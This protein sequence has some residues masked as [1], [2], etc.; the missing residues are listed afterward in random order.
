V[1]SGP[2]PPFR[3]V[4]WDDALEQAPL[5]AEVLVRGHL[6]VERWL[7]QRAT[8][9]RL[10]LSMIQ[11]FHRVMFGDVFPD[12][13]GRLRG[14]APGCIPTN[15]SL[16]HFYGTRY[17]DVLA[18]CN[19]MCSYLDGAI[20]QL[21]EMHAR[22]NLDVGELLRVAAYAHCELVHIHPFVNGNGRIAPP[23]PQSQR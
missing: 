2:A 23:R 15:V 8:V 5:V 18:E 12:L 6:R 16:G 14:P 19:R 10:G 7:R 22:D 21:D 11:S 4:D 1:S 13:A 9:A 17:E 3:G 20:T